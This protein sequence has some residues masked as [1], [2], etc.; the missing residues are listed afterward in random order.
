[1]RK[2]ITCW[3]T[4]WTTLVWPLQHFEQ[5]TFYL[6]V[7]VGRWKGHHPRIIGSCWAFDLAR[8]ENNDHQQNSDWAWDLARWEEVIDHLVTKDQMEH[9]H[10]TSGSKSFWQPTLKRRK[11]WL[12]FYPTQLPTYIHAISRWVIRWVGV[13]RNS[14]NIEVSS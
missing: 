12:D 7:D 8:V 10:K 14:I 11:L 3:T 5:R 9:Q 6:S 2:P 13:C 4:C 1:M